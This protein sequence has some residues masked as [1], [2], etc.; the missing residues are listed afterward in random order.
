MNNVYKVLQNAEYG[1]EYYF[2]AG[3]HASII[4]RDEKE[5]WQYI[6]LQD[7]KDNGYKKLNLKALKDRFECNELT[8]NSAILMDIKS[9]Q[10]NENFA[11][12]LEFI[13]TK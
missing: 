6:E 4:R 13:N 11:D 9:L 7:A 5:G 10:Q 1:K 12:L 8:S 2:G 3:G